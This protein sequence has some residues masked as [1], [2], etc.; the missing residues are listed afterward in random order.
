[1]TDVE[2][3]SSFSPA[4]RL[5]LSLLGPP[6]VLVDGEPAPGLGSQK[7][8][9]L[10]AYLAVEAGR[11]HRRSVLAA[12]FWPDHPPAQ[13]LSNLRQTLSRL[14][15]AIQDGPQSSEHAISPSHLVVDARFVQ[16]NGESDSWLDVTVF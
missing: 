1:M 3:R 16:F 14:R 5:E 8:L 2:S 10:L 7:V 13:A 9:A 4:A 15:R 11:P 12:L 6:R